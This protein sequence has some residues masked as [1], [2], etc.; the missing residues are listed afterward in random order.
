MWTTNRACVALLCAVACFGQRGAVAGTLTYTPTNPSFGGNPMNGQ[1][2]L[3]QAQSQ[4][5][6][7]P[8]PQSLGGFGPQSLSP[9][10]LFAQQLQSQ[11]LN[12]FANQIT[13]ALFGP[14]AQNNGTFSYGNTTVTF[15]RLPNHTIQVTINDGTTITTVIVPVTN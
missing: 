12:S 15:I 3:N 11:L 2:L 8:S 1:F 6:F 10:Q 4:N 14:N 7:N 9:G 5:H 13:Q